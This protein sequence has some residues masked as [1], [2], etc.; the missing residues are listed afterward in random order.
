MRDL[1]VMCVILMQDNTPWQNLLESDDNAMPSIWGS[2][3]FRVNPHKCDTDYMH[4]EDMVGC[5]MDKMTILDPLQ[6]NDEPELNWAT[7]AQTISR[8]VDNNGNIRKFINLIVDPITKYF[9]NNADF[10]KTGFID[11]DISQMK[12]LKPC[13]SITQCFEHP[14][15]YN[16]KRRERQV[17]VKNAILEKWYCIAYIIVFTSKPMRSTN[18]HVL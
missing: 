14:F 10:N 1:Y 17:V 7:Q 3:K 11:M 13:S 4:I 15:E 18:I 12:D 5:R 9:K 6:P 16:H 8:Y 2:Q